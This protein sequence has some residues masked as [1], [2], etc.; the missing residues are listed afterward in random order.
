M[1]KFLLG[2][3]ALFVLAAPAAAADLG[4]RGYTKAPPIASP[5]YNWT[6]FYIGGH[7]GVGFNGNDNNFFGST[8]SNTSARFLGGGQVG[9][10]YQFAPNWVAG[11]EGQYSLLSGGNTNVVFA[12]PPVVAFNS[13]VDGIGSVTGRL[14]YTW[15]PGLLYVKG[16]YGFSDTNN[17]RITSAGVPVAF[18][19][20]NSRDGYTV[21]AGLEYLFAP[22]WSAKLEYQYYNLGNSRFTAGPAVL[23]GLGNI[24]NDLHTLKLGVNYRF[25]W[26]A[27]SY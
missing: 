11:I 18:A 21:G 12:G 6:G 1:K 13:K 24:S 25:G 17:A 7:I 16:G 20:N 3:A 9:A 5:I 22:S 2:T 27:A 8:G 15:G 26:G 23:V 14:G 19:F 10:D 4:A